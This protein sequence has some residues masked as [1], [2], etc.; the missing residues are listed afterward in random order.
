MNF[1]TRLG[2]SAFEGAGAG[3]SRVFRTADGIELNAPRRYCV[4][5]RQSRTG[6]D[7]SFVLMAAC[8][9]LGVGM[10]LQPAVDGILTI[11]VASPQESVDFRG[12]EEQL[13][14]TLRAQQEAD[15]ETMVSVWEASNGRIL[16]TTRQT[17]GLSALS[18]RGFVLLNGRMA[19]L[20]LKSYEDVPLT[21]EQ[22]VEFLSTAMTRFE[23]DNPTRDLVAVE[24][25]PDAQP[26]RPSARPAGFAENLR[27]LLN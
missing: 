6:A 7:G 5:P 8:E 1:A 3:P 2:S 16:L 10:A 17:G 23:V 21:N 18:W 26:L 13:I 11:T 22:G 25:S 20:S 15:G 9:T 24:L 12:Q 27:G 14:T 19:T 4:D